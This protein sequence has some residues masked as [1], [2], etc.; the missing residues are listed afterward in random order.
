VI[1]P[2]LSQ[3]SSHLNA[4]QDL[5]C[6]D[7]TYWLFRDSQ[8]LTFKLATPQVKKRLCRFSKALIITRQMSVL[9]GDGKRKRKDY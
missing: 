1:L 2:V 9:P 7:G 3:Q 5:V 4:A 6:K 8:P